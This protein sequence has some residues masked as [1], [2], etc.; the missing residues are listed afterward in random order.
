MASMNRQQ[1]LPIMLYAAFASMS[2]GILLQQ[3][4]FSLFMLAVIFAGLFASLSATDVFLKSRRLPAAFF[5]VIVT[6]A[7]FAQITRPIEGSVKFHWAFIAVWAISPILL[8]RLNFR[9][10]HRTMLILSAFGLA[11]SCYWLLQPD[12]LSWALK[13][14]FANYPRAEGF[15]SNPI[16]HAET[17]LILAAW[18]LARLSHDTL[19]KL[20]R[21][22]IAVHL[23]VSALV[24]IFS[25]IRSGMLAILILLV[26][27]AL[28]SPNLRRYAWFAIG[29][30][31]AV[32]IGAFLWFGF[33]LASIEERMILIHK[34]GEMFQQHP[35]LGIGPDR[36]DEFFTSADK[37]TGHPHNTLIG[38]AVETGI[39]GFCV[40]LAMMA[41]LL[42]QLWQ[43]R[44]LRRETALRLAET[45]PE[46]AETYP[47]IWRA[48]VSTM[49]IFWVFGLFDYNLVDTE[50]LIAHGLHWSLITALYTR[51]RI[52]GGPP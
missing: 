15:V 44:P 11:Y 22:L 41:T 47:W 31:A 23:T 24:I 51:F 48:L 49:V 18:S 40:Y 35:I 8:H 6:S 29:V 45:L 39:I 21:N 12:E 33:N 17:L 34:A 25:R 2:L 27:Y 14:G 13:V 36:F 43:L 20:E 32:S 5:A 46:Q 10:L 16:T 50:L 37:V 42:W 28:L 19:E 38:V 7:L 9:H 52:S 30:V 4:L 3:I 1:L 26:V